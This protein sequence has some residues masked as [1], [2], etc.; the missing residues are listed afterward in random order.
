MKQPAQP[1]EHKISLIHP[2][3]THI[4][5]CKVLV[6]IADAGPPHF[7]TQVQIHLS[8]ET[9][10]PEKEELQSCLIASLVALTSN[11]HTSVFGGSHHRYMD[12]Y[13]H[14]LEGQWVGCRNVST[15]CL[16]YMRQYGERRCTRCRSRCCTNPSLNHLKRNYKEK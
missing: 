12:R 1:A 2:Q 16:L 14:S 13:V 7:L 3:V 9:A 8:P 15:D 5:L 6:S 11:K 4:G 10:L